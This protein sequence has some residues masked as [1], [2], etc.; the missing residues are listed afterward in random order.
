MG[1]EE[2]D[3]KVVGTPLLDEVAWFPNHTLEDIQAHYQKGFTENADKLELME[4][5]KEL[6]SNLKEFKV[7]LVTN[8]PQR[9]MEIMIDA[10]GIK[11]Y[12]DL[13]VGSSS[14]RASKPAPD[15]ILYALEQLGVK[16][17]EAIFVGDTKYDQIAAQGAGVI[18]VGFKRDA[19]YRINAL[20]ELP[21]LIE[22]IKN[23]D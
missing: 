6:L 7:G 12:F 11:E 22:K 2:Y 16:T 8:T 20:N 18:A 4:G 13:L 14:K 1:R 3:E 23:A 21:K 15:M 10:L 17:E 5:A 9:Q 19:D